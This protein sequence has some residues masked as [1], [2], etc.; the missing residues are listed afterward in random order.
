MSRANYLF[1]KDILS[2]LGRWETRCSTRN[3]CRLLLLALLSP[4]VSLALGLGDIHLKSA[5]NAPLDAEI[6]VV[7]AERRGAGGP[8][9]EARLARHLH[10]L[11]AG[12][13]G[14]P[15]HG[16]ASTPSKTRRRPHAC[17]MCTRRMRSASRSRRCWSRSNWARGHL[18][19][20][21][22]VLLDPPVFSCAEHR[23]QAAA[24]PRR[25]RAM[26]RA[27]GSVR[28]HAPAAPPRHAS[29]T[30]PAAGEL[31]PATPPAAASAAEQSAVRSE[32]RAARGGGARRHAIPCKHGDT[33][34]SMPPDLSARRSRRARS[35]QLVAI[36]RANPSAFDGNM[37]L[38]RA[39]S[40]LSCRAMPSSTADQSGRGLGR[41][42]P[43]ISAWSWKSSASLRVGAC[44]AAATGAGAGAGPGS[45]V[46]CRRRKPRQPPRRRARRQRCRRPGV[47]PRWRRRN[48]CRYRGVAAAS[49]TTA[50]PAQRSPRRRPQMP[51]ACWRYAARRS[52][53]A[54]RTPPRSANQPPAA[55]RHCA[56]G[57]PPAASTPHPR[58]RPRR[59]PAA[60]PTPD[61]RARLR[62]T[63]PP[64]PGRRGASAAR[65]TR[66]LD[67][68]AEY[69]YVPGA[70]GRGADRAGGGALRAR[71]PG[72]CLRSL[73]RTPVR[74]RL[75]EHTGHGPLRSAT[76]CRCARCAPVARA[77]SPIGS[78]SPARTSS[79]RSNSCPRSMRRVTGQHVAI[80]DR[81][82]GRGAGSP[83]S[84]RSAGGSRL[85]H[86]LRSV[87]SG[88]GSGADRDLARAQAARSETEAARGVL[89][90]GQQGALPADRAR[91]GRHARSGAAGRVGKDRDHGP[92][93][94]ARGCACSPM[95]ARCRAP[96]A[97]AW[98]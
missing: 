83:R 82:A 66:L 92:A 34:S 84:G 93:D 13:P 95:P 36:Y 86:G 60:A 23:L 97:A 57:R 62:C 31:R 77:S 30:R 76:P 39:G 27:S 38:L 14:L 65:A 54:R 91:A 6:D 19:R 9:G 11:R 2:S 72:R 87:R 67:L 85:P 81:R 26:P 56:R 68:I 16:D 48:G 96:P 88:R 22:T 94:R 45:C 1:Y 73:A 55:P 49:R 35:A 58:S 89:R 74:C 15:R 17:C 78:R 50:A 64:S 37:N 51:S 32:R 98:I 12:L 18:V 75:R 25:A 63:R 42:A 5:L 71:A 28:R 80:D 24:W 46:S 43:A 29:A 61:R 3:C 8:Q 59:S 4:T 7:G 40:Q 47:Q 33:L 21:Y 41:S 20:E 69:W 10:A 79:P 44:D 52:H 53:A 90:L 70:A